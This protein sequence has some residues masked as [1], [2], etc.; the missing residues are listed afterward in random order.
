MAS[1]M[2]P[3]SQIIIINKQYSLTNEKEVD[4]IVRFLSSGLIFREHFFEIIAE[5]LFR[6]NLGAAGRVDQPAINFE[7][8][9]FGNGVNL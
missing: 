7:N 5:T 3:E 4:K 2:E 6:L 9:A 8:N 1:L